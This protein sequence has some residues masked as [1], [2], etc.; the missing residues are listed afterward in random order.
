MSAHHLIPNLRAYLSFAVSEDAQMPDPLGHRDLIWYSELSPDHASLVALD[1][2]H[3]FYANPSGATWGMRK[4][5]ATSETRTARKMTCLNPYTE[6]WIRFQFH[7]YASR[8]CDA[9]SDHAISNQFELSET[10]DPEVPVLR[11]VPF[12]RT[13]ARFRSRLSTLRA[14]QYSDGLRTDIARFFPSISPQIAAQAIAAVTDADLG[15]VTRL[16]LEK[17]RSDTG[18]SGIPIGA[19][20]SSLLCNLVLRHVDNEVDLRSNVDWDRWTDDYLMLGND[21]DAIEEVLAVLKDALDAQGLAISDAKTTRTWDPDYDGTTD[22]LIGGFVKSQSDL[23]DLKRNRKPNDKSIRKAENTLFKALMEPTP[24]MSRM[25]R[26]LGWLSGVPAEQQPRRRA[27]ADLAIANPA[28]WELA[29]GRM[30][31]YL[32]HV[33]SGRQRVRLVSLAEKL[34]DEQPASDEQ[35]VHVIRSATVEPSVMSSRTLLTQQLLEI[36]RHAQSVPVRGWAR[37]GAYR[38]DQAAVR[39]ELFGQ[40]EFHLLHSLEK[41]WAVAYTDGVNQNAFLYDQAQQGQWRATAR[42]RLAESAW[43]LG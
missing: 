34:L 40:Q 36:A 39:R 23:S 8:L 22:D 18:L 28:A 27:L 29:A 41:R 30:G 26:V 7:R 12:G 42:W 3:A 19:E 15:R 43:D 9:Q 16:V 14:R 37:H 11:R 13:H 1:F 35:V 10:F 20:I 5:D 2:E 33:C 32:A 6:L 17:H 21:R 4:N 38:L 25:R 24:D 31:N